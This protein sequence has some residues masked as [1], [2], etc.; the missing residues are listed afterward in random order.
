MTIEGTRLFLR[1]ELISKQKKKVESPPLNLKE[2]DKSRSFLRD[3][4]N[5]GNKMIDLF[6]QIYT[7]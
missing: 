7:V 6:L 5:I 1:I 3:S 2:T 4:I